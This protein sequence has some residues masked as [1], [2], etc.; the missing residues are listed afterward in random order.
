[1]ATKISPEYF[2]NNGGPPYFGN[3]PKKNNIFSGSLIPQIL[4]KIHKFD[5]FA[6]SLPVL[7]K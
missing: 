2:L 5:L 4:T 7:T 6:Q 1:M 3:I